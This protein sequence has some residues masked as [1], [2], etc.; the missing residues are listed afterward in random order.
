MSSNKIKEKF[1]IKS[2][3]KA[4]DVEHKRK[5]TFNIGKYNDTVINGKK[6][7]IDLDITRKKAKNIKWDAIEHLDNYLLEF[8]K[9]TTRRG[10]KVIWA[11]TALEANEAVLEICKKHQTKTV[12]K[13]KSMVT[14]EIHLNAFLEKNNIESVETDL[15]EY[16]QQLDG[17]APYHIVTPAM[18]KSKED[19]A[20]VFYE[21]LGT[22]PNLT[23][24]EM[25]L[26]ARKNL[27]AKYT[28]AQVGITGGNF[29]I[30]DA[31][32]VCVTE[33]EGNGRLSTSF[34]KVH[35]AI[36]GIEKMLPKLENLETIWP[37]LS[38]FGTGQ[39]ITV[40]NSIFTGPKKENE[41]DGP[42]EFYVIL[43]DNGRTNLI[44]DVNVRESA[45]CIRCGS[46]LNTCPI[47]RNIGGH[48]YDATYSGPIGSVITPHLSNFKTYNHLSSASSLCGSCSDVCPVKINIHG[49]LHY[50]RTLAA[51]KSITPWSE[52]I[53]WKFWKMAMLKRSFMDMASPKMKTKIV[54][55]LFKNSWAKQ[56]SE[57]IF[58]KS[59]KEQ[60]KERENKK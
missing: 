29:L 38:T 12:V 49:M 42:E 58:E 41:T 43:L 1:L 9:N 13:S 23:P 28:E 4:N 53:S 16:I 19:V 5:L 11:S 8:E 44:K 30:A 6:Q 45:Y 57:L 33:N 7:F 47:Y 18:H 37:L 36:V 10:T 51:K 3:I 54:H 31:G 15:G 48:A 59:F 56:R 40:Y 24:N 20:R 39:N 55:H 60:W 26:I 46:C 2:A 22:E 35:I 50:N 32:A 34:P 27:R 17:E 25:T 21:K 14:E 52:N